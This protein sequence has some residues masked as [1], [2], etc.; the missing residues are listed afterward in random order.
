[1]W[2][3]GDDIIIICNVGLCKLVYYPDKFCYSPC[4][5][6]DKTIF[7]KWFRG[8]NVIINYWLRFQCITIGLKILELVLSKI[9][10][11]RQFRFFWL[12]LHEKGFPSN[13]AKMNITIKL[14]K[15]RVTDLVSISNFK[16]I[17]SFW[18]KFTQK[19]VSNCKQQK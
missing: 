3:R 8:G 11:S 17:L 2:S 13:T 1:M 5:S 4:K 7:V 9:S 10:L 12:N 6:W 16:T 15:F 19:G 18:T 14:I